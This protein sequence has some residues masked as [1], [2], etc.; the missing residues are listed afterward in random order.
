MRTPAVPIQDLPGSLPQCKGIEL[1]GDLKL[2][3]IVQSC[4]TSLEAPSTEDFH[5]DTLWRDLYSLTET[6]RTIYGSKTVCHAWQECAKIH[7][8]GHFTLVP[9]S[10]RIVQFGDGSWIQANFDFEISGPHPARCSGTLGV[11]HDERWRIWLLATM[12][13]ENEWGNPDRPLGRNGDLPALLNHSDNKLTNGHS[14]QEPLIGSQ[15]AP[16]GCVVVGAGM[17]GLCAA[18]R[19]KAMGVSNVVLERYPSVGDNWTK[20]YKSVKCRSSLFQALHVSF[21]YNFM[22]SRVSTTLY[23][24]NVASHT[25]SIHGDRAVRRS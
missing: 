6:V 1:S 7:R 17:A 19:L 9:E 8:P 11:A 2:D 5:P 24:A 18:G 14:A 13:E 15:E 22:V 10:A 3:E 21:Q 23:L 20:R 25:Y 4:L 16:Y 12:V